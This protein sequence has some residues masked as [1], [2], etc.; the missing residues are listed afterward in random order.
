MA[1]WS[2]SLGVGQVSTDTSLEVN[3]GKRVLV[4]GKEYVLVK[5]AASLTTM[6]RA[7]V[8]SATSGGLPTF[9][10]NTST[11]AADPYVVGVCDSTQVDIASGSYFLVQARGYAEVISAAAIAAGASVGCST[12]AKK[13]DDATMTNGGTVGYALESAA[14]ADENV[15]VFLNR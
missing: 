1:N 12:T 2:P 4:N 15:A 3:L 8:A 5:A 13:C 11:T 9:A 14:G 6:G 10:V 7:T